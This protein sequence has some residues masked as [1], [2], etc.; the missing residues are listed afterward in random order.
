MSDAVDDTEREQRRLEHLKQMSAFAAE[1]SRMVYLRVTACLTV[2]VLFL[3]QLPF[4]RLVA[5]SRAYK[6]CLL[7]GLVALGA[8]A[9]LYFIYT[10]TA[11]KARRTIAARV[12]DGNDDDTAEWWNCTGPWKEKKW[13]FIGAD[14]LA[15]VGAL[16]LGFVLAKL[17]KVV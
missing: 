2:G 13:A 16:L 12:L 4:E 11:H 3:T 6:L 1:D 9:L 8:A 15:R 17:L 7:G 5:L 14:V 10:N